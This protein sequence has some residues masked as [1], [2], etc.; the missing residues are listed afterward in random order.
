MEK[1]KQFLEIVAM[2]ISIVI[3][4]VC[5]IVGYKEYKADKARAHRRE[6]EMRREQRRREK[7]QRRMQRAARA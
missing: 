7:E 4:I 3:A 5:T 1:M 2:I 6:I